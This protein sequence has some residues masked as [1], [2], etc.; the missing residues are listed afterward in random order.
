MPKTKEDRLNTILNG[1]GNVVILGAGTSIASTYRN[2]E[3][4][5]KRPPSMN[6]FID[7]KTN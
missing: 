5:C 3:P 2:P 1:A 4:N 7:P 6:N